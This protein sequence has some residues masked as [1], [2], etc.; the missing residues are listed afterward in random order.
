MIQFQAKYL[1]ALAVFM[2]KCDI[3]YYLNGIS[4]RPHRE[5]GVVLAATDGHRMLVIHD[6][7]GYCDEEVICRVAPG[8][9]RF[10]SKEGATVLINPITQR[11][12]IADDKGEELFILPG[13]CIVEGKFPDYTKVLPVFANLKMAVSDHVRSNYLAEAAACHPGYGSKKRY[14]T[15][16][17]RLWQESPEKSVIV[18]YAGY[19]EYCGVIMPVRCEVKNTI[20]NWQQQF[21]QQELPGIAEAA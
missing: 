12:T 17:I 16:A 20:T 6:I 21:G 14:N 13:K 9:G 5:G 11:L 10:C 8:M 2:A 1:P 7:H 4:V 15:N 18:E 19:P 3:R